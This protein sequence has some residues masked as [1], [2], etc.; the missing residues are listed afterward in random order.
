MADVIITVSTDDRTNFDAIQR[1]LGETGTAA[2][3]AFQRIETA[4]NEA[5]RESLRLR[6]EYNRLGAQIASNNKIAASADQATRTRLQQSNR[7]L[8]AQRGLIAV[9][10]RQPR[11]YFRQSADLSDYILL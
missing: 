8:Q 4:Q 5:R 6:E 11:D 1:E 2:E 9:E 7:Q 10:Q 3:R